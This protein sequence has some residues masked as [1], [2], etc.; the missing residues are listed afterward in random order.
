MLPAITYNHCHG[1]LRFSSCAKSAGP[2][3][4]PIPKNPS[5]VFMMAV[6]SAVDL[7]DVADQ[8][9]RSGLEDPNGDAGQRHQHAEE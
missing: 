9:E 3:I 4:E 1:T 2:I 6:C 7:R 5:T 8:R